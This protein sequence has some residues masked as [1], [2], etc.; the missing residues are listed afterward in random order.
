MNQRHS[1]GSTG[2]FVRRYDYDDR[3]VLAADVGTPDGAVTVDTVD[4]TAI[5]VLDGD[6]GQ[7]EFEIELPGPAANV[8]TQNGVLTITIDR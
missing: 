1:T 2:R 6:G 4:G 5:V 3:T 8:D 7:E